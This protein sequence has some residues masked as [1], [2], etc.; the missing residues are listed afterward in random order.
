[1]NQIMVNWKCSNFDELNIDE[2]YAIIRLRSEVFVVE[3]NCHY[4]D[5]DDLDKSVFISWV[6]P[7]KEI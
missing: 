2:L 4:Q 3:Q 5:M 7:Q 1:M 6:I